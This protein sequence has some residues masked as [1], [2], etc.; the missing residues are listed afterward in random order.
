VR[1]VIEGRVA[2][3]ARGCEQNGQQGI[4]EPCAGYSGPQRVP[5]SHGACRLTP[6]RVF[7]PVRRPRT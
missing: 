6:G 1:R 3:R 2:R 7:A 5:S 4:A